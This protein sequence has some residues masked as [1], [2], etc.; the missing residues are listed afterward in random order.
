[1]RILKLI[2]ALA[3]IALVFGCSQQSSQRSDRLDVSVGDKAPD[4][5]LPAYPSSEFSLSN[6]VGQKAV[7]LYFYI[8]DDTPNCTK[9]ACAFRDTYGE[10][11]KHGA[12][13]YGVSQDNIAAHELF[14]DEYDIPFP[15]LFDE[16]GKVRELYGEP[17]GRS[18]LSRRITYVIDK[19]GIVR[20]IIELED[21]TDFTPHIQLSL[22][23]VKRLAAEMQS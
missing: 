5:T 3:A 16:G 15:L 18:E 17:D 7:V 13:I 21:Q 1:M 9:Q 12:V 10:Y 11:M 14:A 20:E 4:F 22:A 19:E 2:I 6:Q 23:A 8:G